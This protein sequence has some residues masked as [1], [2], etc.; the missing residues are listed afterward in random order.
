MKKVFLI[1]AVVCIGFAS[2]QRNESA[3]A[4]SKEEAS[5]A[6]GELFDGLNTAFQTKDANAMRN[7]LTDDG[8]FL[9]TD[10][11]EFWGKQ[12]VLEEISSMAKDSAVN[13]N[14]IIDKRE[15]RVSPDGHMALVIEQSVVPFLGKIPVRTIGHATM[16]DGQWK[17][18]FYSWNL[19]P[20]NES[21]QK[22]S[23][24]Y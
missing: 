13:A 9:G 21:L 16:K 23:D 1:L 22:L 8:L 12:R 6:V 10:P 2:C 19:V 20:K 11:A 3:P 4:V 15:I 18:D 24:A 5:K 7:L 17:I 14:H